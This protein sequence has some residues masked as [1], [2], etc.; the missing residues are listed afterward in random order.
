MCYLKLNIPKKHKKR[1]QTNFSSCLHNKVIT[2]TIG[3]KHLQPLISMNSF[4][5]A[6]VPKPSQLS[7]HYYS[8]WNVAHSF[9]LQKLSKESKLIKSNFWQQTPYGSQLEKD[10]YHLW[11][12][13]VW[14]KKTNQISKP[15]QTK[16]KWTKK[17]PNQPTNQPINQPK[18]VKRQ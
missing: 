3:F 8:V 7:H 18:K 1:K 4:C 9:L 10:F 16:N 5:F 11:V 14:R 6:Y 15:N 17:N 13:V 12:A 2:T